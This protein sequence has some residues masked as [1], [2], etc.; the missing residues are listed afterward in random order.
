LTNIRTGISQD[1]QHHDHDYHLDDHI[2]EPEPYDVALR[3]T[4]DGN[5]L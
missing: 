3:I 5:R 2:P 4:K 1:G